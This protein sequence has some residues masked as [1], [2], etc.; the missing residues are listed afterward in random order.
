MDDTRTRKSKIV[1]GVD[2]SEPSIHALLWAAR[3]AKA[4]GGTLEVITAWN[5]PN[6]PTPFGIIPDLPPPPNQLAQV[7]SRLEGVL[8]EH[9]ASLAGVDVTAQVV[10]G[11]AATVL[12]EMAHDAELLVVGSRGRGAIT[13]M[14]LG[15]V[16]EHVVRHAPCPV[17]VIRS[18]AAHF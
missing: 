11:H 6:D 2:G 18:E 8:G 3:Q 4:T 13:G 9:S 5:F 15:S 7:R 16:S 14:L 12:I 1:V 10:P 17:V